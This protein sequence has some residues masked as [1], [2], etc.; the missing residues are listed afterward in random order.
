M[1]NEVDPS[2]VSPATWVVAAGR[3][4]GPDAPMNAPPILAS[5]FSNVDGYSRGSGT[6]T[7]RAFEEVIGGLEGGKAVAFSS[8]MAAASAVF[9]QLKVGSHVAIAEDCYHGVTEIVR[10]GVETGRWTAERIKTTDTGRWIDALDHSDLVW[11]ESPSNPLLEVGD[12]P[13]ICRANRKTG[14]LIAVDNTFATPL[15]QRPLEFGADVSVHSATKY[16]GGHSDLLMGVAVADS[17]DLAAR[18]VE[19]RTFGGATPGALEAFLANRGIRTLAVRMERSQANALTLAERLARHPGVERTRYPGLPSDPGHTLASRLLEG[20]G[21]IVSFEVRGGADIA[22]L[23]CESTRLIRHATSLGAVESTMQ[24]R[25]AIPG[26]DGVPEALIRL[27]VGIE[28][29]ADIWNDLS[30]AL[31]LAG[32]SAEDS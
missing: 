17:D 9:D 28:D 10:I 21:A 27:A 6:D 19:R 5:N 20:F 14:G 31:T 16:I 24:R 15:N 12:L 25:A 13:A 23:V 22:D 2:A 1:V 3:P 18:L 29:V 8:G 7:W 32:G 4:L 11:M 30:Q 26:Q